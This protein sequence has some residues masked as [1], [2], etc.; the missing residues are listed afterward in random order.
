MPDQIVVGNVQI[1]GLIDMVPPPYDPAEFFP[2]VPPE[3]W[4]PYKSDHLEDGLLQL[5]L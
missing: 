2:E 3:A 1:L 4:E 5:Y